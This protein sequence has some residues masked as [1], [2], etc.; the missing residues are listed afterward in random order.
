MAYLPTL[1]EKATLLDV[2]R[3]FPETKRPL[4]E[5]HEVLLLRGLCV[6]KT[7]SELMT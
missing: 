7:L 6:P 2:F 1:P 4:L 5:F 3:M